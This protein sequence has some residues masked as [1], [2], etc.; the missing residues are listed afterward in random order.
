MEAPRAMALCQVFG[1]FLDFQLGRWKES[2]PQLRDAVK[3]YRRIGSGSGQAVALQRLGVLLTAQGR[4]EEGLEV[5]TEGSFIAE[6]AI[7][8]SHVLTRLYASMARNRLAA[9]EIEEA[10]EYILNGELESQ[11]HGHCVTCNA[12]LLPE[13]VRVA[14]ARGRIDDA[15][16]QARN[17]EV[18]AAE[19][20]SPAWK[21]AA[22]QSRARVHAA[23][24]DF[25]PAAAAFEK[26]REE[27]L[28]MDM[29][30]DGARCLDGQSKALAGSGDPQRTAEADALRNA[31]AEE[32]RRIGA[33]GIES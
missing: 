25:E 1:G 23:R 26:A 24:G 33:P 7:M 5:M 20:Q 8:R 6:H 17:L 16:R 19:F 15:D 2:E 22:L 31:A 18:I 27:F 3:E 11:R 32:L 9:E 29:I 13:A 30:Y 4:L 14:L 10:Q 21:A 28:G 12:L